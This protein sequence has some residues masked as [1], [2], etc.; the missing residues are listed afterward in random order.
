MKKITSCLWFDGNAEDAANFYTSIFN[1]SKV[2]QVAR[3]D[4]ASAKASGQ[5]AGS[6]LTIE[7]EIDGHNFLALNGGP[8][9]KLNP[10]IS[11]FVMLEEEKEVDNLWNKLVDGGL[12]MMDLQKY[13]WSE[14]YGWVQDKFGLSWQISLGNKADVGQTITPSLLFVGKQNGRAEEAI[15]LY[16][17]L[18]DNS[19]VTGILKYAAGEGQPEGTV[20]HAQFSLNGQTFMVMDNAGDHNF[21]FNE[22]ISFI[23]NC[24]N[25]EEVD[26]FWNKLTSDGG[27]ESMC[28][29]L[30]DKF[31]VSWQIT[32]TILPRYLTDK[33]PKKSQAV[34][35]AM[36]QMKKIDIA[37]LEKAYKEN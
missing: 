10:S 29:W 27:A 6:V 33:D 31:G 28:G 16:T 22:A 3:Y 19:T 24:E 14:K 11:F 36:L 21:E 32:P 18:F 20:K 25:Q 5:P 7:F 30:K 17:S 26:Y 1:N 37:I 2:G 9:F 13:D 4:E 23:V 15:N 34:M 12:V 8:V 35:K